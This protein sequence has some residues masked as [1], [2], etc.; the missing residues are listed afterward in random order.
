MKMDDLFGSKE[1]FPIESGIPVG[2]DKSPEQRP[3]WTKPD[4]PFAKMDVG[5]SFV[6]RPSDCGG[7]PMIVVQNLC[8]GAAAVYCKNFTRGVRKFTT[9]Q[10]R[11][12]VRVWRIV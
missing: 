8:S 6:V 7:A 10:C 9:R 2:K 12:F 5:D 11:D 1:R 4:F 3:K